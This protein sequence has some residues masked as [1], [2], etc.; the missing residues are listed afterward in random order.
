MMRNFVVT[1][2]T[3]MFTLKIYLIQ[4]VK[5]INKN[6]TEHTYI[7]QDVSAHYLYVLKESTRT[8]SSLRLSPKNCK[9]YST[10]SSEFIHRHNRK[11]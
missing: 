5:C 6:L 10:F 3:Y 8:I 9:D 4:F 11:E 7:E 2:T 1:R